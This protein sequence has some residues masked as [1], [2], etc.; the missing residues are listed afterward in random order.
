VIA[1][2]SVLGQ[3][4]KV[5]FFGGPETAASAVTKLLAISERLMSSRPTKRSDN[6]T[7]YAPLVIGATVDEWNEYGK[8]AMAHVNYIVLV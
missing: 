1:I 3:C 2:S 8:A 5:C 7:M 4:S 6:D